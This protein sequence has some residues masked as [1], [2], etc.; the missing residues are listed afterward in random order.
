MDEFE[1]DISY[2]T[3]SIQGIKKHQAVRKIVYSIPKNSSYYSFIY[4]GI[5]VPMKNIIF[6]DQYG[7]MG[8]GQ[9]VLLEVVHAAIAAGHKTS[10]MLPDGL[11]AL[12]LRAM[13]ADVIPVPECRLSQGKKGIIDI[14]HF[15]WYGLRTFVT[16]IW[17]LRQA[18]LIYVNG[19]R[20][21]PIAG[22]A[23]IILGRAAVYH[24]HLN[25]G[26]LEKKLFCWV[27]KLK[28]TR[29]LILPSTFIHRELLTTD[30]CF[31][32][33][34]VYVIPNGLDNRFDDIAFED[35]FTNCPLQHVGIVGRVS[36]E[37]GQDVLI[38]LAQQFP[39]LHFH[40]LGDAAFSSEAYYKQ[41]KQ[42]APDNIHFHGWIDDLPAKV[43]EIGLQICLIPSR[44]PSGSPERSF[45]AAPLVP[46]QMTAL[47]CLVL[48][49]N[50]GA[51]SD[52]AQTL[53]LRLFE[54]DEDLID[55]IHKILQEDMT[56]LASDVRTSYNHCLE[57]YAHAI[58]Q[59]RLNQLFHN[60]FQQ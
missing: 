43:K 45:E 32:D 51:L 19:N 16:H 46:L 59:E 48:V 36:P 12:K 5:K 9:Q 20:L 41:L 50:L 3:D 13:G 40:I 27:L 53:Q 49:R 56:M 1:R 26:T 17:L 37:K 29:A 47:S 10:V 54:K 55:T 30:V 18:D 42:A 44:C 60:L 31:N 57:K 7:T 58:F 4:I 38:P 2:N 52:I 21:L 28:K 6:L 35:R 15:I 25:H 14:I 22:L 39:R 8:G 33:P 11:C 23:Q 34:R 24:I